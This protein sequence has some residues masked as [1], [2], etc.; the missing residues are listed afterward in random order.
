[1]EYNDNNKSEPIVRSHIDTPIC[2]QKGGSKSIP[3]VMLIDK[4]GDLVYKEI[5]E[6]QYRVGTHSFALDGNLLLYNGLS[7]E[8]PT[9]RTITP[10]ERLWLG[11]GFSFAKDDTAFDIDAVGVDF[12]SIL[13]TLTT[14]ALKD[15]KLISGNFTQK[16]QLRY[17]KHVFE[18][19][20]L[21]I[22]GSGKIKACNRHIRFLNEEDTKQLKAKLFTTSNYQASVR[23]MEYTPTPIAEAL[24]KKVFAFLDTIIFK[25]NDVV[26]QPLDF[27]VT[28][29]QL[30]QIRLRDV[31]LLLSCCIRYNDGFIIRPEIIDEQYSR[32]Y[33]IFTSI[34]S[35]TRKVLGFINYDIGSALQT[36]CLQLV[37]DPSRYPLHQ[38]LM[39]DKDAFRQ[40]VKIETGNDLSWVKKELSKANNLD[41]MSKKYKRYPTLEAYYKEAVLLREEVIEGADTT[42]LE[43]AEAF[44]KPKYRTKWLKGKKEPKFIVDGVKES[45]LFFFIWTQYEREIREAM[46]SCFSVPEACQQVH[47]AVYSK[48]AIDTAILEETVFETTGFKVKISTD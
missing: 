18:A 3:P 34:S 47:D 11:L 1:M 35:D 43:R 46:M 36:I 25:R 45:S 33:S 10:I 41:S 19:Y 6:G 22:T 37:D 30:H 32:V 7:I 5:K 31:V 16:K 24:M 13:H 27:T 26:L 2:S 40:K 23:S 42:I 8:L 9:H 44:A 28:K 21:A 38:E 12:K 17:G 20:L 14:M 4:D 39:N 29:E 15:M 48:E